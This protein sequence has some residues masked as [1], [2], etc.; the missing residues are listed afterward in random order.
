LVNFLR[1]KAYYTYCKP[2]LKR[3]LQAVADEIVRLEIDQSQSNVRRIVDCDWSIS[4]SY[5]L[6]HYCY[7]SM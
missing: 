2:G 1:L 3:R 7:C 5:S 6:I 4:Y